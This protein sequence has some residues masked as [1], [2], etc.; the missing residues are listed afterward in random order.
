MYMGAVKLCSSTLHGLGV[1]AV[2]PV[3]VHVNVTDI[4]G[5]MS[6]VKR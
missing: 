2:G 6:T 1:H 3:H 4:F 5:D